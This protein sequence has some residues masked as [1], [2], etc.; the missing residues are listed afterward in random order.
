MILLD[1]AQY[2]T[3]KILKGAVLIMQKDE[4]S[5]DDSPSIFQLHKLSWDFREM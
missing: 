3:F 4:S 1:A 5:F 2:I